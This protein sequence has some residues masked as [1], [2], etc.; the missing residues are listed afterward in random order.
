M[1]VGNAVH[2]QKHNGVHNKEGK[3]QHYNEFPVT[4]A[5]HIVH[6]KSFKVIIGYRASKLAPTGRRGRQRDCNCYCRGLRIQ[7]PF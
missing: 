5:I 1:I 7:K 4:H 3:D 2:V 6:V